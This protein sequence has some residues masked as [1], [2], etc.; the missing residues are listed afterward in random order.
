[1]PAAAVSAGDTGDQARSSLTHAE[2]TARL[3]R[4]G[5]TASGRPQTGC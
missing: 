2:K 5:N 1:M 3:A 4:P